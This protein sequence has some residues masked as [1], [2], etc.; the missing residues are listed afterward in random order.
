M[1]NKSVEEKQFIEHLEK[2]ESLSHDCIKFF[3][4]LSKMNIS[5]DTKRTLV[6]LIEITD[7]IY[8]GLGT[9]YKDTN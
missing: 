8:I 6:G 5:M 4:A 7:P 3:K 9:T 1:I 2:L